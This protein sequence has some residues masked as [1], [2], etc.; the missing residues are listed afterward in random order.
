MLSAK[1]KNKAEK[2]DGKYEGGDRACKFRYAGRE[3]VTEMRT[4]E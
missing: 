2:E 3:R 1:E 4:F